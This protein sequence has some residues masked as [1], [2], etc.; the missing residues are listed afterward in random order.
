MFTQLAQSQAISKQHLQ[1]P[2]TLTVTL[3]FGAALGRLFTF[4]WPQLP[5]LAAVGMWPM[6]TAV[7]MIMVALASFH[8]R[9]K[10]L[11]SFAIGGQCLGVAAAALI[12]LDMLV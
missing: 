3:L 9:Q 2:T 10:P 5:T 11:W 1:F 12:F 7:A 4:I 6:G 8:L